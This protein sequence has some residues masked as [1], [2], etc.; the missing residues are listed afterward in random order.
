M[1]AETHVLI[2][3]I[4]LYMEIVTNTFCQI[5]WEYPVMHMSV[6][7]AHYAKLVR[8]LE[9]VSFGKVVQL[10]HFPPS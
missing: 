3:N 6:F 1:N 9:K 5:E 8:I 4:V 2:L 10:L 7:W